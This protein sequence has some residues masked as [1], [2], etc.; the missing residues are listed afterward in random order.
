[1]PAPVGHDNT[2]PLEE[3]KFVMLW[4]YKQAS[5]KLVRVISYGHHAVPK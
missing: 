1:M 5:W 2:E 3:G 4:K